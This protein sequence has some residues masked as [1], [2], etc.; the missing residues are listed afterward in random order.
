M[1][2]FLITLVSFLL[3]IGG[4]RWLMDDHSHDHGP[5]SHSHDAMPQHHKSIDP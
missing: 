3:I 5:G 1:R 2:F 4:A